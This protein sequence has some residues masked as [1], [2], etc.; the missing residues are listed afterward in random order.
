MMVA[1]CNG[2]H[3]WKPLEIVANAAAAQ[4]T[5]YGGW[6]HECAVCGARGRAVVLI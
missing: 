6:T 3:T 1:L 2:Y 5:V 4:P